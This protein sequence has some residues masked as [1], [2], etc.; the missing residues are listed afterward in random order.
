MA[1][2]P[3]ASKVGHGLAKVLGIKL[4]QNDPHGK[5]GISRGES[6]FSV[7]SADTYVEEQ[8]TSI[9]WILSITPTGRDIVRYFHNLVPF[10]HWITRYNV[11]WLI[12]DLVAGQ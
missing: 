9:D 11:Q 2:S 5:Q 4:D 3:T 6:V 8:P 10:T 12:G 1:S 7:G